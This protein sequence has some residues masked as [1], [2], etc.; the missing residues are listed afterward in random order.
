M[1]ISFWQGEWRGQY[2]QGDVHQRARKVITPSGG[3][4]RGKF[5]SRK[6]GRMVHHEGLLELDAIYAFETAPSILRYREQPIT[7]HYPDG[8]RLRRYTPD[9]ELILET[10]EHILVEVKPVARFGDPETH[11]KFTQIRAHFHRSGIP[12]VILTD[13]TL[14]REPRQ[15]N[16][17][18]IHRRAPWRLP[19][20][21]ATESALR[22]LPV[23]LP[24]SLAE[25]SHHLS[26]ST[27]NPYC[28]LLHGL[29]TCDLNAPLCPETQLCEPEDHDHGCIYVAEGYEL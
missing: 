24:I 28:L 3:I 12:F 29:A 4:M 16:L 19:T 9:F 14:R 5:P 21:A 6:N 2:P 1:A 22:G 7:L 8:S 13:L 25:A 27:S 23:R 26:G 10:G 15:S 17:R 18:L 20:Y 11:H